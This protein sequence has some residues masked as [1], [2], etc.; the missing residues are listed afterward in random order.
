MLV[1]IGL[2]GGL[3]S[4]VFGIGGGIVIVPALVAFGKLSHRHAT[5]TSVAAIFPAAIVGS[6]TY[7]VHGHVEWIAAVLLAAGVIIGAQ[8]GSKLLSVLP[9]WTLQTFF[10]GF[11]LIVI[12]T[13]WIFIPSRDQEIEMTV[14][15]G[16][17]LAV[18]GFFTGILSNL[19]GV[20]GGVVVVPVLIFFFGAS[21]LAA[22]GTS[23][24][25]MI[26]GSASGTLGN[27]RRG[28]VNLRAAGY[29]GIA[30]A[31]SAPLGATIAVWLD[32]RWSNIAFSVFL[33][34]VFAQMLGR[35]ISS[36]RG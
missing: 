34:F 18:T 20:G 13:L 29:V 33:A 3:L 4:G 19:L 12:V 17:G 30:A 7:V 9:V 23:L 10:L 6:A 22:K 14:L 26:P 25:M 24:L 21:D 35:L 8:L 28:N 32:P 15:S 16:I 11:I 27:T 36:R 1:L 31:L 2:V 5:G